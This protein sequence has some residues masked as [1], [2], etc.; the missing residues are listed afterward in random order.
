MD[1][2]RRGLSGL[3]R[4]GRA[5]EGGGLLNRY[6]G[7]TRIEGSNPF[8]SANLRCAAARLPSEARQSEGGLSMQRAASA[9]KPTLLLTC[10]DPATVIVHLADDLR[11]YA[12]ER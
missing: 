10:N 6:T 4:G 9:G 5:V 3:R 8:L 2:D 11:L 12:S 7:I 1:I